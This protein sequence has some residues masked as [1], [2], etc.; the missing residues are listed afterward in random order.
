MGRSNILLFAKNKSA[1][2]SLGFIFLLFVLGSFAPSLTGPNALIPFKPFEISSQ[3]AIY[4]PPFFKEA[5]VEG[6]IHFLGTDQIGRDIASRLLF[7][8]RPALLL[9]LL[10]SLI[11][12]L[13]A[14]ALGGVAGWYGDDRV[15]L[16]FWQFLFG[17]IF[18]FL[19]HFYLKE[20]SY[21][22]SKEG[23]FQFISIRYFIGM[24]LALPLIIFL[25]KKLFKKFSKNLL[26]P[27]DSIILRILELFRAIPKLFVYLGIFAIISRPS[28]IGVS[29]II[30]FLSWPS[31]ARILRSEI[32]KIKDLPFIKAS[33]NMD[34]SETRIFLKH[35]L[36]NVLAPLI[37]ATAY[38]I[39]SAILVE[40]SLSF[41]Q[42]GLSDEYVSWGRMLGDSRNYI[43][44]WWMVIAPGTMIFLTVLTFNVLADNINKALGN[45]K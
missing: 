27:V 26:I 12:L 31:M 8:I 42:I 11:A 29:L 20:W 7:G 17:I 21:G 28:L 15:I 18:L 5:D 4:Q 44:A 1:K 45:A 22:F 34:F 40:A 14:I 30:G 39:P 9:G 13:I 32:Q 3:S 37:I 35:L 10:A 16:N 6:R 43:G 23:H 38:N 36:P 2:W 25:I 41:L 24:A 33:Q 19:V